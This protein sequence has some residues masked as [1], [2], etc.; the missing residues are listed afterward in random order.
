M[1]STRAQMLAELLKEMRS[2][3]GDY[4][5]DEIWPELH[6]TVALPY[7][8]LVIPRQVR[9]QWEIF[10]TRRPSSDPHWPSTWHLPG[11]IW[12]TRQTQIE[13]CQSVAHRELGINVTHAKEVLT[14]KWTTHPYGSPISHVCICRPK[15][16]LVEADDRGYFAR[17]PKP[18]IAEQVRFIRESVKYLTGH[19]S[20]GKKA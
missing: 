9:G 18:F 17:L 3:Y 4:Y 10:L 16:G 20:R 15:S 11:G 1:N 6:K 19:R 5:P 2:D 7:V 12:R 13:A 8:E 14:Y